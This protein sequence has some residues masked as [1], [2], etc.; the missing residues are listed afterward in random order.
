MK[1]P[2]TVPVCTYISLGAVNFASPSV[3]SVLAWSVN[4]N[5]K[6]RLFYELWGVGW[7][8]IFKV[9]GKTSNWGALPCLESGS[10]FPRWL[11]LWLSCSPAHAVPPMVSLS[12]T[13]L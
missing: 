5:G 1:A 4:G 9:L 7:G 13:T 11:L 8:V 12:S 2:L 6:N 10:R 3:V